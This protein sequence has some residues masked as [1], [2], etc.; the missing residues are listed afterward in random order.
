MGFSSIELFL[1][2]LIAVFVLG[3]QDLI[4]YS[5]LAGRL[6]GKMRH[7]VNNIRVMLDEEALSEN[8]GKSFKDKVE[9]SLGKEELSGLESL[10]KNLS[11]EKGE[12]S[13]GNDEAKKD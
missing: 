10:S 5:K 13:S 7:Q 3:P 9:A 2:L 6:F 11:T 12:N 4:R 8:V 1:I